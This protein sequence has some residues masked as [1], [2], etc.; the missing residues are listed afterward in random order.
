MC[1]GGSGAPCCLHVLCGR[2]EGT[3]GPSGGG[4]LGGAQHP[5]PRGRGCCHI[6]RTRLSMRLSTIS[7]PPSMGTR[8]EKAARLSHSIWSLSHTCRVRRHM[9]EHGD[10]WTPAFLAPRMSL[11][12]ERPRHR[13]VPGLLS[14]LIIDVNVKLFLDNKY[15]FYR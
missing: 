7:S 9:R 14:L 8:R 12:T 3:R 2:T 15:W 4:G 11:L 1:S 13:C 10:P 5:R 6:F